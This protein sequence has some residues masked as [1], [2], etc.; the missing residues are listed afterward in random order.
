MSFVG[1][2]VL[3]AVTI[4]TTVF[5]GVRAFS[6]VDVRGR[7]GGKYCLHLQSCRVNKL[8]DL[9]FSQRNYKEYCLRGCKGF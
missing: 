3:T 5:G 9:R 6:P 8:L 4:K 1:F 7:F 2:D